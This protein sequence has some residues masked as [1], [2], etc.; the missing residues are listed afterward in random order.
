MK[1]ELEETAE[2][3]ITEEALKFAK[4]ISYPYEE[5]GQA[6]LVEDGVLTGIVW[7]AERSYSEEEVI[8]FGWL[9]REKAL[10]N[11]GLIL[12]QFKNK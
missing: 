4:K 5:W 2:S 3:G 12:E 10:T 9:C 6:H 7:Q 11:V 1:T 8:A